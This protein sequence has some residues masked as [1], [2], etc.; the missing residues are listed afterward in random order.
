[1]FIKINGKQHY[2]WRAVDQDGDVVDI[3]LQTTRDGKAAKRFFKR[4]LKSYDS[5]LR[6][7]TTDKT[8]LERI[9]R[10]FFNGFLRGK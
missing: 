7:I 3:L 10:P 6:Q 5:D 4:I 1:V 8:G 9:C 2:S